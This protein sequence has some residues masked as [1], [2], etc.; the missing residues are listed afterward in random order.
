MKKTDKHLRLSGELRPF[1]W[2]SIALFSFQWPLNNR[3]RETLAHVAWH[4]ARI[5]KMALMN[6]SVNLRPVNPFVRDVY[7]PTACQ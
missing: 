6:F 1:A 2:S 3:L 5:L 4:I 7:K